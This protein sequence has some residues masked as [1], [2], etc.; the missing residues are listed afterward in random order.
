MERDSGNPRNRV[1]SA[2]SKPQELLPEKDKP[3]PSTYSQHC[4]GL[5]NIRIRGSSTGACKNYSL[6]RKKIHA[7]FSVHQ[8][9]T[10]SVSGS[11]REIRAEAAIALSACLFQLIPPEFEP[12]G[13]IFQTHL[14][15]WFQQK[16]CPKYK[17]KL[18]TQLVMD[19]NRFVRSKDT[20]TS[21]QNDAWIAI[22]S[23]TKSEMFIRNLSSP[24]DM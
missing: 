9:L 20:F 23:I 7:R 4:G 2:A 5:E 16:K 15:L 8:L 19:I 1:C 18:H 13:T 12:K 14:S 10:Q 22:K 3:P 17:E 24:L 11:V 21:L 6:M